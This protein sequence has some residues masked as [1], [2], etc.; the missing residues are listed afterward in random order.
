MSTTAKVKSPPLTTRSKSS[1]KLTHLVGIILTDKPVTSGL[2]LALAEEQ[3]STVV[4]L[5]DLPIGSIKN[6]EYLKDGKIEKVPRWATRLVL[7]LRSYIHFKQSEGD[8]DYL[9]FTFED[10][11][12]YI[13]SS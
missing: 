3:V 13:A 8:T 9:S 12:E 6:L 1:A 10:F 4:D 5:L 7:V 2:E 11:S